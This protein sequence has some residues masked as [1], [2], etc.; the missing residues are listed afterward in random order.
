[1]ARIDQDRAD[2]VDQLVYELIGAL[3]RW[4]CEPLEHV[5]EIVSADETHIV[6]HWKAFFV[7]REFLSPVELLPG[8]SLA[9]SIFVEE[10]TICLAWEDAA[11]CEALSEPYSFDCVNTEQDV[12]NDLERDS[13]GIPTSVIES[14]VAGLD[15]KS[16]AE[17]LAEWFGSSDAVDFDRYP[18][19]LRP[20]LLEM[21]ARNSIRT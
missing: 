9:K 3:T 1:M 11:L 5:T 14:A 8:L 17:S 7:F 13:P 10:K 21:V 19:V 20:Y 18:E 15:Q 4:Q 16:E 6:L 2:R 12:E